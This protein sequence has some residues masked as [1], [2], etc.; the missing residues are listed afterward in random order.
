[1][2]SEILKRMA[3]ELPPERVICPQRGWFD[4]GLA[5]LWRYRELFWALSWRTVLVRYKQTVVGILWAVLRPLLTMIIFT[6]IFSRI[7][8]FSAGDL[9]YSLVVFA[10]V[11]PWQLFAGSLMTGTDSLVANRGMI[12]KIYFPR[13]IIPASACVAALVNFVLAALVFAVMMACYGIVPSWRIVFL[14]GF[15]LMALVAALG[16]GLWLSALNVR[17]RDVQIIVP[18][19]VQMGIYVSPVGYLSAKVPSRWMTLYA[20]NP[21]VSVIDGFRWAIF[22]P[23]SHMALR[24]G[25]FALSA[26][27]AALLFASGLIFFRRMERTFAD[28]I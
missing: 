16:I 18:Y 7:A 21:M 28:Y 1:M 23:T 6:L 17:F 5:E 8:R 2:D 26:A 3:E 11:L 25:P 24:A 12:S 20:L 15:I 10:G 27:V 14:P 9:P 13:L 19:I 22:G 4:L